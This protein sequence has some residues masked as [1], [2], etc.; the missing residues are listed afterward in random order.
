LEL[1]ERFLFEA[2]LTRFETPLISQP[3]NKSMATESGL[4]DSKDINYFE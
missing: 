1:F 3:G 4:S 2:A